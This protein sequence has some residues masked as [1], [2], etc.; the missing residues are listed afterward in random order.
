MKESWTT[1]VLIVSIQFV[2][3]QV[4]FVCVCVLVYIEKIL[5]IPHKIHY[6]NF[7]IVVLCTLLRNE[8]K[9]DRRKTK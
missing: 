5:M 1:Y 4:S 7:Q 9:R 8:K 6:E 3:F 2:T